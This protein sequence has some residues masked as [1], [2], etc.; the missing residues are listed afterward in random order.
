[1]LYKRK[2]ISFCVPASNVCRMLN[3]ELGNSII[4]TSVPLWRE[5]FLNSGEVIEESFGRQLALVLDINVMI[6]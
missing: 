5:K 2:N 1:M 6:S 4:S 3:V